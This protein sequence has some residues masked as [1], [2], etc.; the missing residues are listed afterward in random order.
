MTT[1]S[2]NSLITP[3]STDTENT[4]LLSV[5]TSPAY[6]TTD[7]DISTDTTTSLSTSLDVAAADAD[8]IGISISISTST[9]NSNSPMTTMIQQEQNHILI[10]EMTR[11]W[12]STYERSISLLASPIVQVQDVALYTKSPKPGGITA[13]SLLAA[14]RSQLDR[15]YYTNTPDP[16]GRSSGGSSIGSNHSRQDQQNDDD[17]EDHEQQQQQGNL[18][19]VKSMDFWKTS[20]TGSSPTI[21]GSN[22]SRNNV[23]NNSKYNINDLKAVQTKQQQRFNQA[24][25]YR[26][27][28]LQQQQQNKSKSNGK[29]TTNKSKTVDS[30]QN[31]STSKQKATF[32]QCTFNL[33]NILMGV[34]LLG[35]PYV[36][37]IAGYYGG[38]F[39]LLSFGSITWY[40]S[41]LIGRTLNGDPRPSYM[42]YDSPYTSQTK[43][44]ML[45]Q[46]TSFPDIARC[47]FGEIGCIVLSL[48]LY[49]EL[50]SCIAI[51][52][53]SIGDHLHQ[54][55][56]SVSATTHVIIVGCISMIPTI[57][58]HTPA[59][60]SYLS[61]VG[62]FATTAVVLAVIASAFFEGNIAQQVSDQ[63]HL[64]ITPPYHVKWK[65]EGLTLGFGLV[66]YCFSGHA[67]IPSIYTSMQRPQDF[68]R[69]VTYTF[70]LVVCCCLAVAFSGYYIFG[71]T[72]Q[73][74]VTLS[75]ERSSHAVTAM[76][77]LT[78]LMVMTAFSKVTLT[79]FPLALGMEEIVAPFLSNERMVE[80]ASAT[81]KLLLTSLALC[82]SI[83][84]PSFSLLCSFVG[85]ICSMTVSVIFPAAAH[86]KMFG[87]NLS[88][89]EKIIDWMF[90]ILG[91]VM[92]VAGTVA[93]IH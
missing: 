24:Q 71:S 16:Q 15:G 44:R 3:S 52:F 4:S 33:A 78:W 74:Q 11:P 2:A 56:P 61:M 84:F 87:S 20:D 85:V 8:T 66:A 30:K 40:T 54:L 58:L 7:N 28:I 72:V 25:E 76:K 10:E 50:F 80:I 86:L 64:M 82:V 36:Y 31:C 88:F 45:P 67:I 62:T 27:K 22:S 65:S 18:A 59:L 73:D 57:V 68:D 13:S 48:V 12:P 1:P 69:M 6:S 23:I 49:F 77:A 90:I 47:A 9:S 34:G 46:I 63:E 43:I 38:T 53:V 37:S 93:T 51:F 60:L 14:R 17:D 75:L 29:I 35:L 26:Q 41:I 79:M 19:R 21:D 5:S 55:I 81:I 70:L 42:F 83:F 92:G 32:F 89:L 39:C 91:I